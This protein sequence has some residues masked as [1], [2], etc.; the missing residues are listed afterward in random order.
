MKDGFAPAGISLQSTAFYDSSGD[1]PTVAVTLETYANVTD[2]NGGK[3]TYL[4]Q[5]D[6][7][8]LNT[9]KFFGLGLDVLA[10]AYLVVPYA[11]TASTRQ[12]TVIPFLKT[13][14]IS[15][16]KALYVRR[17][18]SDTIAPRCLMY[19][20]DLNTDSLILVFDEPV[21]VEFFF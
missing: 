11:L 14:E 20:V 13:V 16:N 8:D 6:S 12:G 9:I 10:G 2:L 3:T 18:Y 1:D 7:E 15:Q 5:L 4:A 17:I 19:N 21:L